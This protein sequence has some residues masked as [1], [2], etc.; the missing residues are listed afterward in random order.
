MTVA[1]AILNY[2]GYDLLS[3][4]LP[5]VI[6]HSDTAHQ[7]FI[8]D[9]KSTDQSKQL[10]EEKFPTVQWIQNEKNF[11]FAE[12][13]NVGLKSI[14]ANIYVLL[15]SDVEVTEN[16][17]EPVL[18]IFKNEPET[19]AVQPKIKD[20]KQKTHFEYAGAAGGMLDYLGYAF[21]RGRIFHD[22]E[23][24]INQYENIAEIQWASGAAMFVRSSY[25]KT[26]H[27]FD[28][29]FFAHMEEI[30]L[31]WRWRRAGFKIQYQP[32]STVF[33]LGGASLKKTNPYKTFLNFRNSLLMCTKNMSL[34]TLLWFI[35]FRLCLDGIAGLQMLIKSDFSH[36]MAII[37]AHFAFYISIPSI[38]KEKKIQDEIIKGFQKN[39]YPNNNFSKSI[40]W[41]Y[42]IKKNTTYR[43][44]KK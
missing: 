13:Y 33:H 9:N 21:C 27:G 18:Q 16:W 40:L 39:I 8:I 15:N 23:A 34:L 42:F 41:N 44:I 43:D 25:F 19:L 36:C 12:G 10:I 1:I 35:P 3:R 17:I 5:S 32:A 24:D 14:S 31:C 4:F 37:K 6:K 29:N 20:F 7:V 38:L 11:G 28:R 2:N 26:F 30:D 22:I